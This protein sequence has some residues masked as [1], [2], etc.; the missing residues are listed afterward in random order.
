MQPIE[1]TWLSVSSLSKFTLGPHTFMSCQEQQQ[2]LLSTNCVVMEFLSV[3]QVSTQN[4][5]LFTSMLVWFGEFSV[6]WKPSTG[7]P[8]ILICFYLNS[9]LL[10]WMFSNVLENPAN[11]HQSLRLSSVHTNPLLGWEIFIY[12]FISVGEI[13]IW[14]CFI[15]IFLWCYFCEFCNVPKWWSTIKNIDPYS[16]TINKICK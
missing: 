14:K 9:S 13:Y 3:L 4:L 16:G 5:C 12:L 11:K 7:R 15:T 10:F 1:R 2:L 6:H 8:K